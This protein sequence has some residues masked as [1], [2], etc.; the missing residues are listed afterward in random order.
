MKKIV[1]ENCQITIRKV[2]EDVGISVGSCH[3]IFSDVLGMNFMAA[4]FVLKFLN[5]EQKNCSKSIAQEL[6]NDINVDPDVLEWIINDDETCMYGFNV[7]NG[8]PKESKPKKARHVQ[9]IKR[10][11]FAHC[12]LQLQW[13]SF[14]QKVVLSM[15]NITL[16]LF[17]VCL[18]E[19]PAVDIALR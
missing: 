8:G 9:S 2:S 19:L 12:F 11:D 3:A 18:P 1:I 15:G 17:A 10:E 4:K 13:R 7:Q 5:L 16:K 6:L 14:C